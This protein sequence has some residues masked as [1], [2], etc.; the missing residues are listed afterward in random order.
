MI[1]GFKFNAPSY[2]II[3]ALVFSGGENRKD[4][5]KLAKKKRESERVAISPVLIITERDRFDGIFSVL[6]YIFSEGV[7]KLWK[8]QWEPLFFV[9][10]WI[11]ITYFSFLY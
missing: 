8:L 6:S 11:A 1:N 9:D 5:V 2:R 4:Q 10:K 3:L 7:Y